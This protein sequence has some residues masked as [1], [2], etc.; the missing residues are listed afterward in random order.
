L[1]ARSELGGS[2][3][4]TVLTG[5][6][7]KSNNEPWPKIAFYMVDKHLAVHVAHPFNIGIPDYPDPFDLKISTILVLIR[8]SLNQPDPGA[9]STKTHHDDAERRDSR[10]IICCQIF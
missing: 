9:T 3:L 4:L 1:D 7:F 5:R 10:S 2:L 6:A 8:F